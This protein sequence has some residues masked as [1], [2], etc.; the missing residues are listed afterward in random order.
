M[1]IEY[2][3]I[4][5]AKLNDTNIIYLMGLPEFNDCKT[6]IH[7]SKNGIFIA[8]NFELKGEREL[9]KLYK[10]IKKHTGATNVGSRYYEK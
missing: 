6:L 4:T 8:C 9:N 1:V 7:P 5:G 3:L 2:M 10:E